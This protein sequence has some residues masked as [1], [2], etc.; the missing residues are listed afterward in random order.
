[1]EERNSTGPR[2]LSRRLQSWRRPISPR[3]T[4]EWKELGQ[5][6]AALKIA[7]AQGISDWLFDAHFSA[8]IRETWVARGRVGIQV[9]ESRLLRQLLTLQQR[10]AHLEELLG[11]TGEPLIEDAYIAWCNA[12][13]ALLSS[14]PNSFVAVDISKGSVVAS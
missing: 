11:L 6:A 9:T 8:D 12:N 1:M 13:R 10:V 4:N 5:R 14:Y 7:S 3:E 2:G